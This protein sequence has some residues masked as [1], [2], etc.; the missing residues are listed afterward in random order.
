MRATNI[1]LT[2]PRPRV[3]ASSW[4]HLFILDQYHLPGCVQIKNSRQSIEQITATVSLKG[5]AVVALQDK[6]NM[7]IG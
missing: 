5:G 4:L 3:L 1:L 6:T 7:R 2:V